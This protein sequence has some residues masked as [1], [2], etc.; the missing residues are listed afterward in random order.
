L[1]LNGF[2]Y[3]NNTGK[4]IEVRIGDR[5]KVFSFVTDGHQMEKVVVLFS[6]VS[7]TN[8]VRFRIPSTV[9]IPSD[10]RS[11]GVFFSTLRIHDPENTEDY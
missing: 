7:P 3:S 5:T 8:E 9:T 1:E 10:S 6:G 2:P 11:L 4:D